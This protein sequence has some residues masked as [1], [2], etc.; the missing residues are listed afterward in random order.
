MAA[1]LPRNGGGCG[2]VLASLLD[3]LPRFFSLSLAEDPQRLSFLSSW[4]RLTEISIAFAPKGALEVFRRP[5]ILLLLMLLLLVTSSALRS[6]EPPAA[7]SATASWA[8]V[9]LLA[10]G[11]RRERWRGLRGLKDRGK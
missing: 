3:P 10:P 4:P 5:V 9:K 1:C 8:A 7:T 11:E 6:V 2:V